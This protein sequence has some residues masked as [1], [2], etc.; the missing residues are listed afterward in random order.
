MRFSPKRHVNDR[1]LDDYRDMIEQLA[2]TIGADTIRTAPARMPD[3]LIADV[4]RDARI[5]DRSFRT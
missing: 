5:A 1:M 2:E 4:L 3:R